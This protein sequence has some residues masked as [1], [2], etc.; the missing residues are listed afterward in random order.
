MHPSLL[1]LS[2]A[3]HFSSS[4]LLSPP[5]RFYHRAPFASFH[6]PHRSLPALIPSS[7][8]PTILLC[9]LPPHQPA[10]TPPYP[11]HCLC[12]P[13]PQPRTSTLPPP[14]PSTSPPPPISTQTQCAQL[15]LAQFW[16]LSPALPCHPMPRSQ[17]SHLGQILGAA[18]RQ[19]KRSARRAAA[20][21]IAGGR[22]T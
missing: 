22:T 1:H 11:A 13:S 6:T 10:P 16:P 5:I 2:P 17:P 19:M 9:S 20:M 14:S 12:S 4:H 3:W 18:S 7:C 8:L 15:L 21:F